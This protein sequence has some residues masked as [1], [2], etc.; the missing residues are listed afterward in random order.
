MDNRLVGNE[1]NLLTGKRLSNI[2]GINENLEAY[3]KCCNFNSSEFSNANPYDVA[4]KEGRAWNLGYV[5]KPLSSD[6]KG[7]ESNHKAGNV[8]RYIDLATGGLKIVE[9]LVDAYGNITEIK[10]DITDTEEEARQKEEAEKKRKEQEV[11][12]AKRLK[13]IKYVSIGAVILIVGGLIIK[14][15]RK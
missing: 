13:V 4:S 9:T 11:K 7:F 12:D 3:N 10:D 2:E 14:K 8:Q 5:N 6:L 1:I 15:Y